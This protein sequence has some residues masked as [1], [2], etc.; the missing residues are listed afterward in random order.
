MTQEQTKK[1]FHHELLDLIAGAVDRGICP[2]CLAQE[3]I[4]AGSAI[5]EAADLTPEVLAAHGFGITPMPELDSEPPPT[6]APPWV[7]RH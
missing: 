4:A 5:C 7:A 3:L 6:T 1:Q 2:A